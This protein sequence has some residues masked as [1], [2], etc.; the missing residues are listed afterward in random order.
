MGQAFT[1]LSDEEF[2]AKY[3]FKRPGKSGDSKKVVT[4][5]QMGMQAASAADQLL[6]IGYENVA[7]YK[8]SFMDWK[9][10]GNKIITGDMDKDR[11][12]D[13]NQ[14]KE[15]INNSSQ[16]VID[17]RNLK[18]RSN[19]GYI[20]GVNSCVPRKIFFYFA[21]YFFEKCLK[22]SFLIMSCGPCRKIIS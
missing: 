19:P 21:W 2:S 18:E 6:R 14:V 8:G 4:T 12:V 1:V 7:V 16:L 11:L 3:D 5:C 10:Q 15:A 13:F 22:N 17:V 20:S 9:A